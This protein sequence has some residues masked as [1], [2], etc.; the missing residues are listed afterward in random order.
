[1]M[2]IRRVIPAD[3]GFIAET[4]RPFVEDHWASFEQIAPDTDDIS[5]RIAAAGDLY[6]WLIAEDEVPLAY[7]YASPH[8]T[9]AAYLSSVDVTIYSA[10]SARGK[11]VGS[12]LY[13]TLFETL[14]RQNYV[15]AFAGIALPNDASVAIHKAMGF[16]LIGTYPNVGYKQGAWRDTQ[17]WSKPLAAPTEP[18]QQISPV[19][20]AFMP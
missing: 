17:W 12:K 13:R 2:Q 18:P 1:M 4:Y 8:R 5:D 20:V 7:A 14:K 16:T 11:G 6:P 3:A 15:M 10:P 19:S 9:R